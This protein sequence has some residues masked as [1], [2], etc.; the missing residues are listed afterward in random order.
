[1]FYYLWNGCSN[2]DILYEK[3]VGPLAP[4][5]QLQFTAC[6]LGVHEGDWEH[7]S[8]EIC[9]GNFSKILR[10]K[11]D[12]HGW[13]E[14][15]NCIESND[16][17]GSYYG[18]TEQEA[19][20]LQYNTKNDSTFIPIQRRGDCQFI[21]NTTHPIGHVA[22]NSH[23][24][25]P[26]AA[27]S[28]VY[29]QITDIPIIAYV[30]TAQ[31]VDR[32]L[33]GRRF[34]I[35]TSQTLRRMP[36][37]AQQRTNVTHELQRIE[38]EQAA[39]TYKP[40]STDSWALFA[41][42][43]GQSF[44]TE[45]RSV[46]EPQCYFKNQTLLSRC[47]ND[48][49]L[50]YAR[51]LLGL[52]TS[53]FGASVFGSLSKQ[54]AELLTSFGPTS[55]RSKAYYYKW[56]EAGKSPFYIANKPLICATA[57]QLALYVDPYS[58]LHATQAP[59]RGLTAAIIV[60]SVAGTVGVGLLLAAMAGR[61]SFRKSHAYDDNAYDSASTNQH[62]S[63]NGAMGV[64]SGP[65]AMGSL[66]KLQMA[67]LNKAQLYLR[68]VARSIPALS[69]VSTF[70]VMSGYVLVIAALDESFAVIAIYVPSQYWKSISNSLTSVVPFTLVF[71]FIALFISFFLTGKTFDFLCRQRRGNCKFL[72]FTHRTLR[73]WG[74]LIQIVLMCMII[75]ATLIA[76]VMA[77]AGTV[78]LVGLIL[79]RSI[80]KETNALATSSV[81]VCVNLD[82][83]GLSNV[84]CGEQMLELCDRFAALD[85]T[86]LLYGA[87][88]CVIGQLLFLMD[89]VSSF[90]RYRHF[91]GHRRRQSMAMKQS[92]LMRRIPTEQRIA[93]LKAALAASGSPSLHALNSQQLNH[94][95]PSTH[96]LAALAG[97]PMMKTTGSISQMQ[98]QQVQFLQPMASI[99][100]AAENNTSQIERDIE[101]QQIRANAYTMSSHGGMNSELSRGPMSQLGNRSCIESQ[102]AESGDDELL[103]EEAAYYQNLLQQRQEQTQY[104]HFKA[105]QK[106]QQSNTTEDLQSQSES[107]SN[108]IDSQERHSSVPTQ[109]QHTFTQYGNSHSPIASSRR[110]APHSSHGS[111][112]M[113]TQTLR[114]RAS[115]A[116]QSSLASAT[117]IVND[118]AALLLRQ[119]S[120]PLN[121][122][123]IS[124]SP[125]LDQPLRA[126][127]HQPNGSISS[128]HNSAVR[129]HMQDDAEDDQLEPITAD[130]RTESRDQV[131]QEILAP[132]FK[133][134]LK[135]HYSS[136]DSLSSP[137]TSTAFHAGL[138]TSGHDS[139][140]TSAND[141]TSDYND[142]SCDDLSRSRDVGTFGSLHSPT[143]SQDS[144]AD[145]SALTG[146]NGQSSLRAR[147]MRQQLALLQQ[148]HAQML[149]SQQSELHAD[150]P[151]TSSQ[152][153][154]DDAAG[155]QA[156]V[157]ILNEQQS[158][159]LAPI[160]APLA[161]RRV[162][163]FK[164]PLSTSFNAQN[165]TQPHSKN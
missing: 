66:L 93:Q 138:Q 19:Y 30:K 113:K 136:H 156:Q 63:N 111:P 146:G 50:E 54:A 107:N 96:Q 137:H 40:Y 95:H 104:S 75:V 116:M 62:P 42:R 3:G 83:I 14:S 12:Q 70:V 163:K 67:K 39:G 55:P 22:L 121:S 47:Q 106:P 79:V 8:I 37:N 7:S 61:W 90:T 158:P 73:N 129:I 114:S 94:Q 164:R 32:S 80:C 68:D 118:S 105:L 33:Y 142:D 41:G 46:R 119:H 88:M 59:N 56:E 132:H 1:M 72:C 161:Q 126:S 141:N 9:A 11:F 127:S 23:A 131:N 10:S 102:S 92:A 28:N 109:Q 52:S 78:L 117:A 140:Y 86:Q 36:D 44:F 108:P 143:S 64:A 34:W 69:L 162:P 38:N 77:C 112:E 103:E 97:S 154:T 4:Q 20:N 165:S 57:S 98:H 125:G 58:S 135:M 16:N 15:F 43:W 91:L 123:Y 145:A 89:T 100:E 85:R 18:P 87:M 84:F 148:Q 160:T 157:Y 48:Q 24:T 51:A 134:G 147:Q 29:L 35:G 25:Y 13:D 101:R 31:L 76:V 110:L 128:V 49:L 45:L 60:V 26:Y 122:N 65:A 2:Q 159:E 152:N 155:P 144:N 71:D 130:S 99:A 151:L 81:G 115:T 17:D 53:S 82:F 153:Q 74:W 5:R 27:H 149:A 139:G 124:L 120:M 133:R 21:A 150:S 6:D